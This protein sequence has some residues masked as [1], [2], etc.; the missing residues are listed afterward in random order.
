VRQAL[1]AVGDVSLPVEST[2]DAP[3]SRFI[4]RVGAPPNRISYQ[5]DEVVFSLATSL[6]EQF[7]SFIQFPPDSELPES[8]IQYHHHYDGL[9]DDGTHVAPDSLPV[10]FSLERV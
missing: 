7:M 4:I 3:V 1:G 10:V 2:G 6:G 8:P 5:A 9:A